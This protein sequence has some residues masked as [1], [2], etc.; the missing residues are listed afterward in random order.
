MDLINI[1]I[2][3]SAVALILLLWIIVGVRHLS[4]LKLAYKDRWESL[5]SPLRK[6]HDLL[7]NFVETLRIHDQG[8]EALIGKLIAVRQK[9]ARDYSSGITKI[10]CEHDFSKGIHEIIG[11][12]A[13]LPELAKDTNFL[14]LRTEFEYLGRDIEE[15]S[16]EYNDAVRLYNKHSRFV[17]IHPLAVAFRYHRADIFEVEV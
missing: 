8:Q 6:R 4:H 7:P 15:K 9:A 17:L 13:S 2:I 5:S 11:L 14:E 12:S 16:K 1:L 10:E 3:G